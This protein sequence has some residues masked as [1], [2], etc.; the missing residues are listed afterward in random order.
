MTKTFPIVGMHCASCAVNIQ[1]ALRKTPGVAAATVNYATEK[2]N[3][4]YDPEVVNES[5]MNEAIKGL[6]YELV[7]D[8]PQVQDMKNKEI[9][10]WKWKFIVGGVI[11]AI[12]IWGSFTG[13]NW[14]VLLGLATISQFGVGWD[15]YRTTWASLKNMDIRRL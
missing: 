3:V 14:G 10:R 2:A 13:M 6:G 9:E 15:F 1:R 5:K 11:S 8:E 4:E 12:S 7:A